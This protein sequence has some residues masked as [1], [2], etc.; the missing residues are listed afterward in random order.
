[1]GLKGPFHRNGNGKRQ[2]LLAAQENFKTPVNKDSLIQEGLL[3]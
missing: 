3:D 2:D 1:M